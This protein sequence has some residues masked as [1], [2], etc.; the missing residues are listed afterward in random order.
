MQSVVLF[1]DLQWKTASD[2]MKQREKAANRRQQ[3]IKFRNTCTEYWL[4]V[5]VSVFA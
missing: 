2:E 5:T 1:G 3:Q 4:F